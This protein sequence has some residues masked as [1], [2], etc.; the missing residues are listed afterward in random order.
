[1]EHLKR[2]SS[3]KIQPSQFWGQMRRVSR[4]HQVVQQVL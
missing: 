1:M 2:I 4:R 3:I